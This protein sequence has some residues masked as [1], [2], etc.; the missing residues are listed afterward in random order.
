MVLSKTDTAYET[1]TCY[2]EVHS[3]SQGQVLK[4]NIELR[5]EICFEGLYEDNFKKRVWQMFLSM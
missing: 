1:L 5:T 2:Q 4:D 3:H